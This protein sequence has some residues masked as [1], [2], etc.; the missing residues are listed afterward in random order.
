[1]FMLYIGSVVL[2]ISHAYPLV[3]R[4][5]LVNLGKGRDI[6]ALFSVMG[7]VQGLVQLLSTPT[8]ALLSKIGPIGSIIPFVLYTL[9]VAVLFTIWPKQSDD[10]DE[11]RVL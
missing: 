3:T 6:A 2:S 4:S 5:L 9:S 7:A 1:M 8:S 10:V 11:Q